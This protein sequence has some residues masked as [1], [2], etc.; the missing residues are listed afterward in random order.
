MVE[1]CPTWRLHSSKTKGVVTPTNEWLPISKPSALIWCRLHVYSTSRLGATGT[2]TYTLRKCL[3]TCRLTCSCFQPGSHVITKC[4]ESDTFP[5]KH[6]IWAV[7]FHS[8][9]HLE[10]QSNRAAQKYNL[11]THGHLATSGLT[12]PPH[13]RFCITNSGLPPLGYMMCREVLV[14]MQEMTSSSPSLWGILDQSPVWGEYSARVQSS[15]LKSTRA[16]VR[17]IFYDVCKQ[18]PHV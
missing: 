1:N 13:A 16:A 7:L 2:Q 18:C 10:Q 8:E 3:Q 5:P 15:G 9:P 14:V 12:A 17:W 4:S 6:L 11:K